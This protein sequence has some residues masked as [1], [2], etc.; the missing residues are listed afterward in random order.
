MVR[1]V[2]E[3]VHPTKFIKSGGTA[4][5]ILL[6]DGSNKAITDFNTSIVPRAFQIDPADG[7][8]WMCLAVLTIPNF[9]SNGLQISRSVAGC[10]IYLGTG[11]NINGTVQNQWKI[12]SQPDNFDQ[13]PL[14]L[15]IGLSNESGSVNRGLRI[16]AD[17]NTLSFNGSVIAGTGVSNGAANGQ[18]N[19]SA[20]NPILWGVNSTG[21]EGGFYSNRTNIYWR[22]RTITLGSVLP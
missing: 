4:T 6:A 18:V 15:T 22:A 5:Q 8:Y 3:L 17:G 11:N 14:G 20:G 7:I 10:G 9:T 2:L 13:N 1:L 16:S 19:Y 12:V 21:T